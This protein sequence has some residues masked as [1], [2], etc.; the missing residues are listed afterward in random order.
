MIGGAEIYKL[1]LPQTDKIYLTE[2]HAA[3]EGDT[4]FEISD[5]SRF[6]EL[7]R[8]HH[9]IDEKHAI[10]FDIVELEKQS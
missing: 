5:K 2:V 1:A 3:F 6:K 9:P 8:T 10:A 7:S 4:I